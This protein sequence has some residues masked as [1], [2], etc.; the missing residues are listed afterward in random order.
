MAEECKTQTS[1]LVRA[2]QL[3][4]DVE[5]SPPTLNMDKKGG[6]APPPS[7]PSRTL[8]PEIQE[9]TNIYDTKFP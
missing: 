9:N 1:R 2:N 5:A 6:A 4:V 3:D 7:P 8:A